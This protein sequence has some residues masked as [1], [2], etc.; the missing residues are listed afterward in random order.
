MRPWSVWF[1]ISNTTPSFTFNGDP[2][3]IAVLCPGCNSRLNA[4]DTAAGKTV[5][6]PKCKEAMVIPAAAAAADDE[7]EVVDEPT[8]KKAPTKKSV[9]AAAEDDDPPRKKKPSK[10]L[11]EDDRPR[12][13]RRDVDDEDE[14]ENPR[15]SK[16]RADDDDD[17]DDRPR[18][19]RRKEAAGSGMT[20]NIIGGG[21]LL[22][23]LGIAGFV[24]YDRSKNKEKADAGETANNGSTPNPKTEPPGPRPGGPGT[25]PGP[26]SNPKPP[27]KTNPKT[28]ADGPRIT[29]QRVGGIELSPNGKW[30]LGRSGFPDR[31]AV[32]IW[33]LET[34]NF[35]AKFGTGTGVDRF[36]VSADGKLAASVS[37]ATQSMYIW[38]LPSGENRQS[39]KLSPT[40]DKTRLPPFV[41]FSADGKTV[42][43]V[44]E[45]TLLRV[46]LEKWAD[47]ALVN[48]LNTACVSYCPAKNLVAD[49][50]YNGKN[51]TGSEVRIF[52]LNGSGA[53]KSFPGPPGLSFTSR[54]ID[55]SADGSTL[56]IGSGLTEPASLV[57]YDATTGQSKGTVPF[58]NEKGVSFTNVRLSP[59]GRRVAACA[60]ISKAGGGAGIIVVADATGQNVKQISAG[61]D[62]VEITGFTPDG[63]KL[64][65]SLAK[66]IKILEVET[67]A[68][69]TP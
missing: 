56:A 38:N 65:Y 44:L 66:G 47:E 5:K 30:I 53:P 46:N 68:E 10:D 59:D 43:T 12:G 3:P 8:R 28:E 42:F 21:V 36:G 13:K 69:R 63:K 31:L 2:M 29:D 18:K 7:F 15:R 14:D 48:D 55:I 4:P 35:I 11:N 67:G 41:A 51:A 17:D 54:A 62:F 39:I 49:Y 50:R 45:K 24:W 61:S 32:G 40:G 64:A 33:E 58:S 22:V 57:L 6:C 16:K 19:K 52:D 23:A 9:N 27:E 20:R 25:G 37:V 34:G 60:T 26:G 1:T